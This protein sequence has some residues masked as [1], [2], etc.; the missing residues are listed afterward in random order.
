MTDHEMILERDEEAG[1]WDIDAFPVG[2]AGGA[3]LELSSE[4][5][6]VVDVA[7]PD[8]FTVSVAEDFLT[9]RVPD[10]DV[11]RLELLVGG[12]TASRVLG[13]EVGSSGPSDDQR[14]LLTRLALALDS[15]EQ[16]RSTWSRGLWS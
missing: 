14:T 3:R 10:A 6:I 12:P 1:T 11:E 13:R 16:S 9:G 8:R 5:E 4:L 7:L 2:P 15:Q